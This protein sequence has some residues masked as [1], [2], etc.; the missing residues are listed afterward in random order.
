MGQTVCK[1]LVSGPEIGLEMRRQSWE[2]HDPF[3]FCIK[4]CYQKN[5]SHQRETKI[6]L[7]NS[8]FWKAINFMGLEAGKQT[9]RI[10]YTGNRRE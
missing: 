7:K 10:Y 6:V 4:K 8:I 9:N 2:S 5:V 1:D 3:L